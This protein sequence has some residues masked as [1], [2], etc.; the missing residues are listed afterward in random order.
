MEDVRPQAI[1]YGETTAEEPL[2][3]LTHAEAPETRS[4]FKI[5]YK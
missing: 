1:I 4:V 5:Q 2:R 3:G